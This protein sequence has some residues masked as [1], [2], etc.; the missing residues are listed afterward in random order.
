VI[1]IDTQILVSALDGRLRAAEQRLLESDFWCISDIVLWEL[2]HLFRE[3]RIAR[4]FNDPELSRLLEPVTVWP[5]TRE[6]ALALSR[7]DFRSH[8]ADEIISATSLAH[9]IP[10][11]TRDSRILSSKLVPLALR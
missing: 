10:L 2:A 4:S 6:V 5:I 9:D 1:N 11:L 8:P 7:L 3:G